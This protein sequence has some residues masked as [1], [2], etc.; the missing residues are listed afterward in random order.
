MTESDYGLL[1][2]GATA[3]VFSS[4]K[5]GH[6][7][8]SLSVARAIGLEPILRPVRPRWLFSA[9]APRGPL[10]PRDAPQRP[11]SPLAPPFPDI[12]FAAGRRT[13]PYLAHLKRASNGK[14]FTVCLQDP[15]IGTG[16]ADLIWVP[17]H[18]KLRGE[19]VLVTLTSPHGLGGD[20]MKHARENP[21]PRIAAL[22]APRVAMVLGGPSAHHRFETSD[23]SA[24]T[25]IACEIIAS[26]HSIMVTPSRR[27]PPA[28]IEAIADG[29][30]IIG[31]P[32]DRAFV[33]DGSGSNPYVQILAHASAIV[34]TSDSVNMMGEALVTGAPVHVY[35]PTGGHRKLAAFLARLPQSCC[36]GS[37]WS[38]R[39][40]SRGAALR[41]VWRRSGNRKS[42]R[43]H[44]SR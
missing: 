10:D 17:E 27:T 43:T 32:A 12:A 23:I 20:V 33:W 44:P 13:I 40:R 6:E 19:N 25:R 3:W 28:L 29:L 9:L 11:G 38:P 24:L 15:R 39:H 41:P 37:P 35:E 14:V 42:R 1:A 7:V 5:V 34:V 31:A 26:G 8:H 21:D 30:S 4:G 22:V 36:R 18:D 16:A 2:P